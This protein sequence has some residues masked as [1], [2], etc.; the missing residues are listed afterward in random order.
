MRDRAGGIKSQINA[1]L[2]FV[3]E[4]TRNDFVPSI[5]CQPRRVQGEMILESN[6]AENRQVDL[7]QT[8]IAARSRSVRLARRSFL[9]MNAAVMHVQGFM[10]IG[11]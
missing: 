2:C 7:I 8:L 6:A 4:L 3:S 11:Y 5:Q 1:A 10:D 9:C